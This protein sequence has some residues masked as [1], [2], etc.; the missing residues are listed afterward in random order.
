MYLAELKLWNFR[1]YGTRN[2]KSIN[3]TNPG[4]V[5]QFQND[6]NLLVGENDSGK[7]AILDA[8]KQVLGTQTYDNLRL[9]DK[10]FYLDK[11]GA[12]V[13]EMKIE[14]VFRGFTP[15]EAA[16]FLE[17]AGFEKVK[18]ENNFVL[19]IRLNAY[20]NVNGKIISDIKAGSDSE[21]VQLDGKARNLLRITYLKPLRDADQEL[22]SG[23]RSRLAHILKSH[24]LFKEQKDAAGNPI[25]HDLEKIIRKANSEIEDYFKDKDGKQILTNINDENFKKFISKRKLEDD[26]SDAKINVTGREL[27]DILK[28]L[29]LKID[30]NKTGLGTQNLLF[31]AT[32]LILLQRNE[33]L[34]LCLI[35]EVEA[36]LHAQAQIRLIEYLSQKNEQQFI[37]TSHSPNLASKVDLNKIIIC[38]NHNVFPICNSTFLEQEDLEFL[39][40]FLD[41]TKANLFFAEG[42][43]IVEGEAENILVPIIA[44]IIGRSLHDWGVS[45]I[46][47]GSKALL[48]YVKIFKR[49]DKKKMDVPVACIT[50]LDIKQSLVE[51]VV[52]N[53]KSKDHDEEKRKLTKLAS[54]KNRI[55]VFSSPLWTLEFD[56]ALGQLREPLYEA[57][58]VA[59]LI[60]SRTKN[61]NFNG[62]T[63]EELSD[64]RGKAREKLRSIKSKY[65]DDKKRIAFEIYKSVESKKVSKAVV[66]QY[67]SSFLIEEKEKYKA[68]I[69]S[70]PQINY[71]VKAIEF[72][73]KGL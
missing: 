33:G 41:V 11:S 65:T 24:Q 58:H 20:R 12:R 25:A 50:D 30:E 9:D 5:V 14:C 7:T 73:T 51:E 18:G 17:W 34:K 35:E 53:I 29:N 55:G 43:I 26:L 71:I 8:I 69:T 15:E 67:L 44:E 6:L 23:T 45:I 48:R 57:I 36:H 1:K 61:Q 40:R 72:V 59:Q 66:A 47:V 70:D 39:R 60:K 42:I 37:L 68:I 31:I 21:G 49:K 54:K 38:K 2:G 13:N 19:H 62:L 28:S 32:E 4:L 10:D 46:N 16:S 56:L 22:S 3:E 64:R 52:V 63:K 27:S